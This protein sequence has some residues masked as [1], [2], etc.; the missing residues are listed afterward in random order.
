MNY[1]GIDAG[2]TATKWAVIGEADLI[3]SGFQEG[4]DGHIYRE[5]SRIRMGKVL[6]EIAKEI[7]DFEITGVFMGI[8]GFT[9][10][11]SIQ[12]FV[13]SIFMC[14]SKVISDIE[15]A[16]LANFSVG[17]GILLYAGTG[18]VAYAI[19]ENGGT[20]KVG[21]WGYLLGDEGAGY[22]I[23]REA[24]RHVLFQIESEIQINSES[25]AGK[26]LN[27][28]K[29]SDV[30]SVKS[31][32]YSQERFAIAALSR[33]VDA[34]AAL[35]DIEAI[36]IMKMAAE[37]LAELVNRIDKQLASTSL[38]IKFTGGISTSTTLYR[39]LDRLLKPRVSISSVNIAMRAAELA[40]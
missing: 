5:S 12:K 30:S 3:H 25:L 29:A 31:F 13:D 36:G 14:R 37:N 11:G 16:Y 15:L 27:E 20:H 38:P 21:G 18:S 22:W 26:I 39:E 19:D 24:I 32:A 9:N 40:R 8:T 6:G 33:I 10:D 34:S 23:G 7:V 28:M 2:A 17:R 4:M 1:L 35:G